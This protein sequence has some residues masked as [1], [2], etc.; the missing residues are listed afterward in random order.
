MVKAASSFKNYTRVTHKSSPMGRRP[1]KLK[2][3]TSSTYADSEGANPKSPK[4]GWINP[5]TQY[6]EHSSVKDLRFRSRSSSQPHN[7][8]SARRDVSP[9]ATEIP[10]THK[11]RQAHH[12]AKNSFHTTG[13]LS[14]RTLGT[15]QSHPEFE[16]DSY[17]ES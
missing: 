11:S 17:R 7:N 13:Q 14:K 16:L 6:K 4:S 15:R 8:F 3:E 5:K 10:Q 12:V 1:P 9:S 2:P